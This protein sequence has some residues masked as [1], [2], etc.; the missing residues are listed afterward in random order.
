MA[1]D[2]NRFKHD[3]M[4]PLRAFLSSSGIEYRDG[5]GANQL[6]QINVPGAGWQALCVSG[7]G[8]V[9]SPPALRQIATGFQVWLKS[10]NTV[11]A[12]HAPYKGEKAFKKFHQTL[13][14]R[15]GFE[16]DQAEWWRDQHALAEH[17]A[18][19]IA[20]PAPEPTSQFLDDLRDDFAMHALKGLLSNPHFL[21][22]HPDTGRAIGP[23][24]PE[25][26]AR[27][28]Y[29]FADAMMEAKKVRP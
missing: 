1:H 8:V 2:R 27:D 19:L 25:L 20:K 11:P 16:H 28:A 17:I 10:V 13:C 15:F 7:A 5:K 26:A 21:Q 14:E 23:K 29:R 4:A 12:D 3:Q 6:L 18:S 22:P 9:T 24:T